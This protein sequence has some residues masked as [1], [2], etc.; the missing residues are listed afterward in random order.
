VPELFNGYNPSGSYTFFPSNAE[1][2]TAAYERVGIRRA[3]LEVTHL[4]NGITELNLFL[5]AFNNAGPNLA[6]VDLQTV[7]LT[8]GVSS[9]ALPANTVTILD[10]FINTTTT[11]GINDLYC[12]QISRTEYAAIPNKTVQGTPN[13]FWFYRLETP[14]IR[15]YPVPDGNGPYVYN[16]YRFRQVQDSMLPNGQTAEVPNR[17]FDAIVAGLAYRLSRIYRPEIEDKRK[18]DAAEAWALYARQDTE[19][20]PTYISPA[21]GQYYRM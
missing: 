5:A 18:A 17:A 1:I 3:N 7:T 2:L 12:Y 20:T 19:N 14:E 8:T 16:F 13:Q 11:N 9:Y 10:A 15:V 21:I 4:Q 6:Q